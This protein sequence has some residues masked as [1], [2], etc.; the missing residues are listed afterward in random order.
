MH[1]TNGNIVVSEE[2]AFI[3]RQLFGQN[4]RLWSELQQAGILAQPPTDPRIKAKRVPQPDRSREM[5]WIKEH[6]AKYAGQ[7]VALDGDQLLSHGTDAHQV[8]ADARRLATSPFFAH[9]D[10]E[11]E[12]HFIGGW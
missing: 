11:N 2:G 8:F 12:A 6:R 9:L 3:P 4:E 7:W 10:P 5:R 1:E